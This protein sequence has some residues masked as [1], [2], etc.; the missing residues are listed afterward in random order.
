MNIQIYRYVNESFKD[1]IHSVSTSAST[2]R[3]FKMADIGGHIVS[4]PTSQ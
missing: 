2:L 1:L 3:I 4:V